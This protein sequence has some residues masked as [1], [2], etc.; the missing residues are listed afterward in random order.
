MKKNDIIELNITTMSSEGSGI[1]RYEGLAVFVPLTAIG[2]IC[3]VKILKVKSNCAFGKIEEIITPSPDRI[4]PDCPAFSKCGGCVYRH[5]SY[6]SE[7]KI[8][9]QRVEDAIKRIGGVDM[10]ARE[11]CVREPTRY[12]NKAQYPVSED[13]TVGFY[14]NHSHDII[15][16]GD[17][18]LQPAVFKTASDIFTD[19]IRK[20][21]L[22]VYNEETGR[23]LVRHLYLRFAQKT[24][25]LMVAV[26]INGNE[27]PNSEKL[28][29]ALKSKI[30]N[31]KT[32]VLNI[33]REKTNVILGTKCVTLYGD[34]HIFDILSGV[35]VRINPLSFYQVNR[36]MAELLYEKAKEY[37]EPTGKRVLDLYCGAGTIG[38]SMAKEAAEIIGVEI[39]PEA[40][41]DAEFN[42]KNNGI[43]N[44]RFLCGDAAA[45]S[46]SLK[47]E[48]VKPD[49]VILD[50]PRKGC[51]EELLKTVSNDFAPERIVYISC[52]PAT[53]ARDI[54]ILEALDYKL[55]EYTPFDLFPRTHHVETVALLSRQKL[56]EHIYFDA[57]VGDLPKTA[58][59]TAIY[60]EIKA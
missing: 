40:I 18:S 31:L 43:D 41:K 13:Y 60:P 51:S 36:N 54:K 23:G 5:I 16:S 55:M 22:S 49:V 6:E 3:K 50:P 10:T 52:D 19:F 30:T 20:N 38:L 53:L 48:G 56:D 33:N 45:A 44:A 9:R 34:G 24:D 46:V 42:A 39:I 1:G 29:E 59:T 7:C 15:P 8:K 58:R 27:L 11:I 35:K 25:E 12:R 26:V 57:N 32:V 37:A 21:N 2:D 4:V 14:R 17:C 28:I 47:N